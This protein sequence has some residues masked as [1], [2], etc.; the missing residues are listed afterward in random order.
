MLRHPNAISPSGAYSAMASLQ[1]DMALLQGYSYLSA[2]TTIVL[3]ACGAITSAA[4]LSY[5]SGPGFAIARTDTHKDSIKAG[6]VDWASDSGPGLE[7]R[8][9][10][11]VLG[12]CVSHPSSRS[13]SPQ[14]GRIVSRFWIDRRARSLFRRVWRAQQGRPDRRGAEMGGEGGGGPSGADDTAWD[15]AQHAGWH[16]YGGRNGII[17]GHWTSGLKDGDNAESPWIRCTAPRAVTSRRPCHA[18]L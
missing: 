10:A 11:Q 2:G 3:T 5:L 4:Q 1:P 16:R 7:Q 8:P 15:R 9:V 6:C 14:R 18:L 17:C 13:P 12:R